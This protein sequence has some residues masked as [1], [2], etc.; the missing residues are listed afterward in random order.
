MK[1]F[2]KFTVAALAAAAMAAPAVTSSAQSV[3]FD[4][5]DDAVDGEPT[6]AD[7]LVAD[8]DPGAI[9]DVATGALVGVDPVTASTLTATITEAFAP[10]FVANPAF[11]DEVATP[12][13]P[14]FI[15]SGNVLL[16]SDGVGVVTN[17]AGNQDALG[18]QNTSISNNEFGPIGGGTESSD[19]NVGE[20]FSVTFNA[21]V[22]FTAIEL[23]SVVDTDEFIVSVDGETLLTAVGDNGLLDDLAGLGELTIS[24]GTEVTFEG[25]GDLSNGSVRIESFSVN[26]VPEP[27]SLALLGLGGL[28][29]AGRRRKQA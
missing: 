17:I 18:I 15:L 2:S 12:D 26:V 5:R 27:A 28:A 29:I 9:G 25:G 8:F 6:A 7:L 10:E 3:I 11:V 20:G 4:F 16:A 24:A 13:E 21:D 23:E 22:I 1:S 14:A 19:L